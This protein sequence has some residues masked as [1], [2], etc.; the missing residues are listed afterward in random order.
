MTENQES[1]PLS[2]SPHIHNQRTVEGMMR[3]VLYA[4]LPGIAL[5]ASLYGWGVL[6][7]IALAI[8]AALF[9][10]IC[11]LRLGGK[12]VRF[13]L[14]DYSHL[15]AAVLFALCL[16]PHAAWWI[17]F[18]GMGFAL[19]VIK[20]LYGGL[21]RN[22]FNPAMAGF[23]FILLCFPDQFTHW[24]SPEAKPGFGETLRLIFAGG[25]NVDI[26]SGATALTHTKNGL[27]NMEML[28]GLH[29]S[30]IYGSLGGK[31]QEWVGIFFMLGG[32]AL[33]LM[34]IIDWRT[35]LAV[36]A[37]VFAVSGILYMYDSDLYASPLFHI[38]TG[39]TLLGAFFVATE[40]V[41]G[42]AIRKARW[43]YGI[44]IGTLIVLIRIFGHYPDG[45]AFAVIA[46]N[47]VAPML[48]RRCAP[49]PHYRDAVV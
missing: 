20:H 6:I 7:Q 5:Y 16:S 9:W 31:Y 43:L 17:S 27:S 46:M 33:C 41:S 3:T 11:A 13:G 40:P 29:S 10:E 32:I 23:L 18:I 28:S 45:V 19:A 37:S 49:K 1:R 22:L 12:P 30:P 26:Y 21:G 4:L 44:G 24:P 39:G 14:S 25:A 48:D 47:C 2:H 8:A 35:P 15:V 36:L 42:V 34:R 38:F